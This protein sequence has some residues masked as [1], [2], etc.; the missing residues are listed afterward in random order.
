MNLTELARDAS[1]LAPQSALRYRAVD[2][3]SANYSSDTPFRAIMNAPLIGSL[4]QCPTDFPEFAQLVTIL[5]GLD[6]RV[7]IQPSDILDPDSLE[8]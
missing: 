6:A 8:P 5:G 2:V 1:R 3:T 7:E 4:I